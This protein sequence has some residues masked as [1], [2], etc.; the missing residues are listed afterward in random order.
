MLHSISK[1]KST[2]KQPT[3]EEN[4]NKEPHTPDS[5]YET[6]RNMDSLLDSTIPSRYTIIPHEQINQFC[7][8]PLKKPS[9]LRL[10]RKAFK[11]SQLTK[12]VLYSKLLDFTSNNP[13]TGSSIGEI[14]FK[15][16]SQGVGKY[17]KECSISMNKERADKHYPNLGIQFSQTVV[18]S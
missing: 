17:I 14:I 8:S 16:P 7:S 9:D 15:C 5:D 6:C 10:I 18:K 1:G 3:I 12:G 11:K 2:K 4:E 13:L